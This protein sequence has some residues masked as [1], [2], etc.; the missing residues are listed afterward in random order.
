MMFYPREIPSGRISRAQVTRLEPDLVVDSGV[1]G[2]ISCTA[3]FD[4]VG[5]RIHAAVTWQ[6]T[7]ELQCSRCAEHFQL[8][9]AGSFETMAAPAG[10]ADETDEFVFVDEAFEV[11]LRPALYD[12]IMTTLPLM[13]LC[14]EDCQ[15]PLGTAEATVQQ[16]DPRWD[17]LSQLKRT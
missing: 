16:S 10:V 7:A 2:D 13:P 4:R 15:G 17:A 14:G 3:E 12:D 5:M 6:C 9:I 1:G 11:D 8:P